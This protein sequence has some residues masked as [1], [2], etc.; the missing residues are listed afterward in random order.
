MKVNYVDW[1]KRIEMLWFDEM[2]ESFSEVATLVG[3]SEIKFKKVMDG[4][5]RLKIET[6]SCDGVDH[7]GNTHFY[8]SHLVL[9]FFYIKMLVFN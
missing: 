4:I 6:A 3:D 5:Q 8:S 2:H 9:Y 1:D 7:E